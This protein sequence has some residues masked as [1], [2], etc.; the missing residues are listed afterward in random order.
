MKKRIVFWFFLLAYN[1]ATSQIFSIEQSS[2]IF[3]SKTPVEDIY[4]KNTNA[5]GK[6]NSNTG[7]INFTVSMSEFEFKK[8]L[9]KQHFNEK[10]LETAKYPKST[11]QGKLMG[12]KVDKEGKQEVSAVGKFTI[13]G[14]TKDINV[15]GTIE[16][17]NGKVIAMSKFKVI[18]EDY[19][20]KAPQLLWRKMAEIMDVTVQFDLKPL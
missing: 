6:F 18:L 11:F 20:I 8:L 2:I 4:G 7:D 19:N 3:F 12:Y 1:S 17:K 13:H 10:Y 14:L 16:F 9:M 15:S 5:Q